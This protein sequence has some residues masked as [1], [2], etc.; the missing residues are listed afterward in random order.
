MNLIKQYQELTQRM[1]AG[2]G[3]QDLSEIMTCI[4]R[5]Q[6]IIDRIESGNQ[7]VL[8][9]NQATLLKHISAIEK[10]CIRLCKSELDA[11]KTELLN[12][13]RKRQ[14]R[15]GYGAAPDRPAARFIDQ[16]IH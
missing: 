6:Q 8:P 5:R 3:N 16:K 11:L 9:E 15:L 10:E 7:S 14:G 13:R 4:E 2:L 12:G 1:Q